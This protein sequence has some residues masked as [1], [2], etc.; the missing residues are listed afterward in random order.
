MVNDVEIVASRVKSMSVGDS[1]SSSDLNNNLPEKNDKL[2]R[3][4]S[5]DQPDSAD[6]RM[7]FEQ[8]RSMSCP[9]EI[10]SAQLARM[11]WQWAARNVK[12]M[13][14]PWAV[15]NIDSFE[16]EKCVR[17]VYNPMKKEW[18]KDEC[19]VKMEPKKFE[20]GAMR[21]CFRL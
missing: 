9:N 11:R 15:F 12:H 20:Q 10:S 19:V 21:A 2:K 14:D 8:F 7:P 6:K 4:Q 3:H 17:H 16:T 5:L 1:S 18:T 13:V